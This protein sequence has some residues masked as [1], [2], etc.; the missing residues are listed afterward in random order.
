MTPS[1]NGLADS[2]SMALLWD[3]LYPLTVWTF[4]YVT[5]LTLLVHAIHLTFLSII[6]EH[7]TNTGFALVTYV[8]LQE[9]C[10]YYTKDLAKNNR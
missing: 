9:I 1:M 6:L 7:F 10:S 5:L 4:S 2:K 3:N 8:T